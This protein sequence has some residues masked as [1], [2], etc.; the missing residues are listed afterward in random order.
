MN[1]TNRIFFKSNKIPKM[2]Y[3]HILD[4]KLQK[5]ITLKKEFQMPFVA[6][7]SDIVKEDAK[8]TLCMSSDF[9][10]APHQEFVKAYLSKHTPY[11][12]LL[13]YHGMGSGKTCSAIGITEE[14]RKHHKY[15][16]QKRKIY[17]V[18]SP[19]VQ[20]NFKL[21]LFNPDELIE[22]NGL[23]KMRRS[24]IGN[25]LLQEL[26]LF[27]VKKKEDVIKKIK[28]LIRNYYVF[29]GYSKFANI[30]EELMKN[31]FR[32]NDVKPSNQVVTKRVKQK[33]RDHFTGQMIVIDEVHN[34][35][36]IG[37]TSE[38]KK[39]SD[40][41]NKLVTHVKYMKLLF[42]SGTPM[43]NDPKE[44]VFLLNLLHKNDGLSPLKMSDVFNK[45]DKLQPQGKSLLLNAAN[46]YISYVRGEDPYH[47]PFKLFPEDF[48]KKKS[49]LDQT[50]S[51]TYPPL[52]FNKK[53]IGEPMQALDVYMNTMSD[54]QTQGYQTIVSDLF[55]KGFMRTTKNGSMKKYD[56]GDIENMDTFSYTFLQ[57]PI[58]ALTMCIQNSEGKFVTGKDALDTIGMMNRGG[59]FEY[60]GGFEKTFQLDNIH[61]YSVKIHSILNSIVD[62]EGIVLIYSQYLDS[63]LIPMA[64]ALE[65]L[66]FRRTSANE[67][68]TNFLNNKK[69]KNLKYAMITGDKRYTPDNGEKELALVN[70]TGNKDGSLCKVVLISMAGSEGLD[71]KNLR[72]V[73]I[74]DPWYNLNR[75]DQIIGRAIRHCSHKDLPLTHRNCQVFL[76]GSQSR[77]NQEECVDVMLY[78]QA[79]QKAQNI[80][81]IQKLLKSVSVDCLVHKDQ[82]KYS[83]LTQRISITL[84]NKKQI[85]YDL[86]DKPNSSICDYGEC[87]YTC[88]NQLS[89]HDKEDNASYHYDHTMREKIVSKIKMLFAKS[90]VYKLKDIVSHLETKQIKKVH[91]YRALTHLVESHNET[92]VDK[93]SQKGHLVRI[94]DA[95]LFQRDQTNTIMALQEH[96]KPLDFKKISIQYAQPEIK[97]TPSISVKNMKDVNGILQDIRTK[98]DAGM[99]QHGDEKG[100]DYYTHF[101]SA[102]LYMQQLKIPVMNSLTREHM[103]DILFTHIMDELSFEDELS[104]IH[105]LYNG[106]SEIDLLGQRMKA[107]Y[108]K[109]HF[110]V[111]NME[112]IVLIHLGEKI[113]NQRKM[114]VKTSTSSNWEPLQSHHLNAL[115]PN[116]V[117]E[118]LDHFKDD[119]VRDIHHVIGFMETYSSTKKIVLKTKL[120]DVKRN[121][122][123]AFF[124]QKDPQTMKEQ[125]NVVLGY[126]CF[127]AGERHKKKDVSKTELIIMMEFILRYLDTI[128]HKNKKYFFQKV[129]NNNENIKLN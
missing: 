117:K 26:D 67:K 66:G 86:K 85:S 62:S 55:Q 125:L 65:E 94:K 100:N 10:L 73:H 31:D 21:Q 127:S 53:K 84:S 122:R 42:L 39:V 23:W 46:G 61:Q 74:L 2:K 41:L 97:E 6:K 75:V 96:M 52:Q 83:K 120:K 8:G 25:T 70:K 50:K 17:I 36:N 48:D 64:L 87:K 78:R 16:L 5:K 107:Y 29:V 105:Y 119:V 68:S 11:N 30:I 112:L 95:Y 71:F 114:F 14:F 102:M 79:E 58:N 128:K 89:N 88:F 1:E 123:G 27:Q 115:Q 113:G 51:G 69:E 54:Y 106:A 109:S 80:G 116:E 101:Q 18:A 91:I 93:F 124:M 49:I 44:I 38:G 7:K 13:L 15:D 98:F 82:R 19:N 90:H 32:D 126:E 56:Y 40:T 45:K 72:Q 76:H 34:V 110:K 28:G 12:G 111:K 4:E 99:E 37:A 3:P 22:E 108:D 121:N 129:E 24:C 103:K 77:E 60:N 63:G 92:M 59:K 81:S 35:R 104:L 118:V 47:F 43:Y 9:E 33:L 57:V 20:K